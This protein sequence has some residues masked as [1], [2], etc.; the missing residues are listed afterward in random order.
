MVCWSPMTSILSF[1]LRVCHVPNLWM[2]ISRSN[3]AIV[4]ELLRINAIIYVPW[5][6]PSYDSADYKV[7]ASGGGHRCRVFSSSLLHLH[8]DSVWRIDLGG[9]SIAILSDYGLPNLE[10]EVTS[11]SQHG[12]V[13]MHLLHICRRIAY[14]MLFISRMQSKE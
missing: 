8:V 4:K 2:F 10:A 1:I 5:I 3:K 7:M 9:I 6:R 11:C 12:V 14:S 13:E